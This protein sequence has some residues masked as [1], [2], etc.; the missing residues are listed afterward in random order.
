MLHEVS[1]K[2]G[3]TETDV[4]PHAS[5]STRVIIKNSYLKQF[6][7]EFYHCKLKIIP[8]HSSV[9]WCKQET[10]SKSLNILKYSFTLLN[11]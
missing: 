1:V 8:F 5:D 10:K 11:C 2:E 7:H 6:S 3:C 9:C 4:R